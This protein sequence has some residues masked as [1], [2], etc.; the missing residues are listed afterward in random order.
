MI[1]MQIHN[2]TKHNSAFNG[3]QSGA[4]RALTAAAA[5]AGDAVAD[6]LRDGG[7]AATTARRF[8][9]AGTC[10][11]AHLGVFVCMFGL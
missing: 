1:N 4:Y 9:R 10:R 6:A 11:N 5:D 2:K 8:E 3:A 7:V